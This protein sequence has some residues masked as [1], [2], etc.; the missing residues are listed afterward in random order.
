MQFVRIGGVALHYQMIGDPAAKPLIVFVNA[1]GTDF[2]IWRDVIVRLVGD[3]AILAYDKRGHGLS[4]VGATPYTIETHAE[5]LAG[6]LDHVGARGA[7]VCGVSVGGMIA[8]VLSARRPDL[9]R[10][11]VL[12]DTAHKSGTPQM[13]A[14]RTAAVEAEGIASI[15]DTILERWFTP[16]F[17]ETAE[18]AGYRNMLVRQPAAGYAATCAALRDAD[19]T[20]IA[21]TIS[22]PAICIVGEADGSTPPALVAEFARMVPN[23][24]FELIKRCGHLPSIEQPETLTQI[25]RAFL[26]L[27]T[28]AEAGAVRH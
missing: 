25:I 20:E 21:R 24:R 28:D 6:L 22:V 8:Q 4:D 19:L 2:R 16:E 13:W 27:V 11:L 23:A 14:E 18:C 9:V 5:D 1:L 15:A 12:C 17:R 26:A 3:Y 7:I 10:A